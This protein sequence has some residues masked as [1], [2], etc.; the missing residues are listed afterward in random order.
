MLF[1]CMDFGSHA[2]WDDLQD[3]IGDVLEMR[4]YMFWSLEMGG[5]LDVSDLTMIL[6]IMWVGSGHQASFIST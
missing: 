4:G 3:H 5:Y 1:H 2:H 6:R